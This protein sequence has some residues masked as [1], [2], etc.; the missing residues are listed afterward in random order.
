MVEVS[1]DHDFLTYYNPELLDRPQNYKELY[2][3]RHSQAHNIVERIFGVAKK[4]F[5]MLQ[6][7]NEYPILTQAKIVSA[8]GVTHNFIYTFYPD[9]IPEPVEPEHEGT[10]PALYTWDLGAGSIGPHETPRASNQ[11]EDIAKA[12]W[13]SYQEFQERGQFEHNGEE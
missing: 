13:L 2:N 11:N 4:H 8:C 3:L 9:D 1:L 6:E 7:S 12:M 10:S 5:A